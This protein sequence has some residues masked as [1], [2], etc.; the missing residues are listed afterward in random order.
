MMNLSTLTV[1]ED[2]REAVRGADRNRDLVQQPVSVN[3]AWWQERLPTAGL[4]ARSGTD[5]LTRDDLFGLGRGA[6]HSTD[7]ALELLWACLSWGTGKTQRNNGQRIE[8]VARTSGA[9]DKLCKA[10]GISTSSPKEA[11]EVLRPQKNA[12]P[13]LGPP[14]FTKFLYFAGG[15]DVDHPSLILDSRVA[16][17]LARHGWKG[18]AGTYWWPAT[19]Y[20]RYC[21]LVRRWAEELT[22]QDGV[23]AT[24]D[25]IELWLFRGSDP[26]NSGEE[27][28]GDPSRDPGPV[29]EQ[30]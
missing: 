21:T 13:Y 14:F 6:Q 23:V 16:A 25:Q 9:T 24:P 30:D 26:D 17:S 19:T 20:D 2:L 3:P 28:A 8:A 15:G 10:A 5:V 27:A 12:V 1:P 22:H 11:Y 18:L 29:A 7:G 4:A